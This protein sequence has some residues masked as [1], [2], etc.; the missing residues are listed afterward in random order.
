MPHDIFISPY[1]GPCSY[2]HM[3]SQMLGKLSDIHIIDIHPLFT[4]VLLLRSFAKWSRLYNKRI[5]KLWGWVLES[6]QLDPW[7]L[8]HSQPWKSSLNNSIGPIA[9]NCL[10][11]PSGNPICWPKWP[12][13]LVFWKP[14]KQTFSCI[15]Q[16]LTAHTLCTLDSERYSAK[17]LACWKDTCSSAQRSRPTVKTI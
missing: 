1:E 2:H 16:L 8:M 6:I 4:V 5:A 11:W 15:K 17:W 3:S 7:K 12:A 13:K 9:R 14:G 10:K